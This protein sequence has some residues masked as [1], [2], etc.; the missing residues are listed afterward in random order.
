MGWCIALGLLILLVIM[1]VGVSLLYREDGLFL[2]LLLGSVKV[3]LFP[4]PQKEKKREDKSQKKS[5]ASSDSV[6]T[7]VS[8]KKGGKLSDFMPLLEI[9]LQFLGGLRRKLRVNKMEIDLVLAS[10]DPCDLAINYGRAWAAVGN[11]MPLLE[12][13]FVIRKRNVQVNCDFLVDTTRLTARLDVT[14]TVGR[15]LGLAVKYGVLAFREYLK[16]KKGGAVI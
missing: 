16:L 14:I 12:Q 5:K 15:V 4:K 9:A 6:K 2:S 3:K 10:D 8:K 1:P 7:P 13:M 11:L